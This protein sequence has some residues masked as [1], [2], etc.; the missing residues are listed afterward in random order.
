MFGWRELPGNRWLLW[1]ADA[2]GHGASAALYTTLAAL[3]FQHAAARST[4]AAEILRLV[5]E[6]FS[7]VFR[8]GAFMSACCLVLHED[9]VVTY[10]GAGH[11]PLLIWHAASRAETIP[12]TGTLLG[13]GASLTITETRC[14][15]APGDCV[16]V[17]S[18]GLYSLKL[19]NDARFTP[20]D[21][22]A[23]T[24]GTTQSAA[25]FLAEL[26]AKMAA[27]SDGGPFTDDVCAIALCWSGASGGVLL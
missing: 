25:A 20:D 14:Q 13:I 4:S 12:S 7:T 16:L 18:D 27:K 24:A 19:A 9:G 1:L 22:A 26:Q 15:L 21:L 11:P 10:A 23:S 8:R 6:E 3:L 5:N 17:Y 2:T